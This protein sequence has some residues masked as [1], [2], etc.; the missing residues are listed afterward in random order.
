MGLEPSFGRLP[1]VVSEFLQSLPSVKHP[2]RAGTSAEKPPASS[3]RTIAVSIAG[4]S[5]GRRKRQASPAPP[6][7]VSRPR[8]ST[9]QGSSNPA[10]PCCGGSGD[11]LAVD[12][13]CLAIVRPCSQF[14]NR[15]AARAYLCLLYSGPVTV[16]HAPRTC[17]S[18]TSRLLIDNRFRRPTQYVWGRMPSP[19]PPPPRC[20][21]WRRCVPSRPTTGRPCHGQSFRSKGM[22]FDSSLTTAVRSEVPD[23]ELYFFGIKVLGGLGHLDDVRGISTPP[24]LLGVDLHGLICALGHHGRPCTDPGR[25]PSSGASVVNE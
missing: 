22:E 23:R 12:A 6:E 5:R 9:L 24:A 13:S 10:R 1:E 18:V 15:S 25:A 2:G 3:E 7:S 11:V 14:G 19:M 4:N 17:A 16:W 20:A 21:L 8:P